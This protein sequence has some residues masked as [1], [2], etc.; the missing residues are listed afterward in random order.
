MKEFLLLVRGSFGFV[1]MSKLNIGERK[2]DLLREFISGTV[3][4]LFVSQII[5]A[6]SPLLNIA[7]CERM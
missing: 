7:T 2:V 6:L 4:K 3:K 1:T 5:A